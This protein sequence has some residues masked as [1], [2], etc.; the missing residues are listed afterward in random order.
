MV[1]VLILLLCMVPLS[2]LTREAPQEVHGALTVN[3]HQAK[4]LHELGAMF[5]DIRPM[6]EWTWGHVQGALHLDL[7]T[8]FGILA[9]QNMPRSVPLVIYCDSE[10]CPSS[11]QAARMAVAWD[12][13]R[14]SI[15]ATAISP[16]SWKISRRRKAATTPTPRS[17][18]WC[19]EQRWQRGG[20]RLRIDVSRA[21]ALEI[22]SEGDDL[23]DYAIQFRRDLVAQL[24]AREQLDQL[25]VF[26][27]RH[28]VF[29]G[30]RQNH[31]RQ[32]VVA[33]GAQGWGMPAIVTEG[34][35]LAW[36][37]VVHAVSSTKR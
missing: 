25:G 3:A 26:V 11:A 24:Q 35:R 32:F 15:S 16:G 1:R 30:D 27:D 12:I 23:R 7:A 8:G 19:V 18:L 9:S 5:V 13:A 10:I 37:L 17:A 22:P 34:N 29:A 21:L 20:R 6:R 14:S 2:G 36:L 33:L 31:L 28:L 4:R